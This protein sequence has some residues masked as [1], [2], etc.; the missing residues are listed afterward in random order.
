MI[1]TVYF[2]IDHTGSAHNLDLLCVYLS[3]KSIQNHSDFYEQI[4]NSIRGSN[5]LP[6]AIIIFYS[7]T[8]ESRVHSSW[9]D[10]SQKNVFLPRLGLGTGISAK[11]I[12]FISMSQ[13]GLKLNSTIGVNHGSINLEESEYKKLYLYGMNSLAVKN[14]ILHVAPSGHS[15]RHPSGTTSKLFIQAK[16]IA[17]NEAELQ[18]IA[19]G[20]YLSSKEMAWNELKNVFI[21]SMGIYGIVKEALKF[22][23]SDAKIINFHSYEK[24]EDLNPPADNYLVI[25]SASTSGGM[26]KLLVKSGFSYKRIITLVEVSIRSELC[27]TPII[28]PLEKN[29]QNRFDSNKNHETEIE[30]VGEQFT[31]KAKQPREIIL[32]IRHKPDALEDVLNTFAFNGVND[33]NTKLNLISS[34]TPV[35]SLKPEAL[36]GCTIFNEWL[37]AELKWEVAASIS[38]IV[39]KKDGASEL[40]ALKVKHLLD[41]LRQSK[42]GLSIIEIDDLNAESLM[43]CSGV[44]VVSAFTGDGGQLRQISR[45]LREYEPRV[46]PRHFLTGVVI[47][48]TMEEWNRLK[49][50]LVQNAM[51]RKYVFS[52]WRTLPIG[53]DIISDSWSDLTG[54]VSFLDSLS[55]NDNGPELSEGESQSIALLGRVVNES[56]SKFLPN[57][58]N[59]PLKL[60]SGFVFFS[61]KLE[62]KLSEINQSVIFLAIASVLQAAREHTVAELC[63]KS[64]NYQSV[65][66]SPENFLRFNDDILQACIL[67]ASLPNEI[68]Y[69]FDYDLSLVMSEFLLKV[70]NRHNHPYGYAALE[71]AAALATGKLRLKEQHLKNLLNEILVE[72]KLEQGCLHALLLAT[73]IKNDL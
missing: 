35:L 56:R 9:N 39:Y 65:V 58:A 11:S 21:D 41:D 27:S 2:N 46:I 49:R 6:D 69:S 45:S 53:P 12:F 68:D 38:T 55:I 42:N 71:F 36:M 13:D 14:K 25:I 43:D 37:E 66:L 18:F 52:A 20:I 33:F 67:R 23:G 16:E 54:L 30:L 26:A 4:T 15:F 8:I 72:G 22:S 7:S 64:D 3:D 57:T 61:E 1:S 28:I 70:F 50:Y 10:L 17:R 24:V 63:L 59:I 29:F 34:S 51:D 62:D 47:S 19:R 44:M 5:T 31:S 60:T 73:K 32:G 48:Q 40:L